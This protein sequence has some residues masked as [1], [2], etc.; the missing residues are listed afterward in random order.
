LTVENTT[1]RLF[2]KVGKQQPTYTV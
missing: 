1:D 2:C